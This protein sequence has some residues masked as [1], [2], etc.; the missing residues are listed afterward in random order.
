MSPVIVST[1]TRVLSAEVNP[2]S[3]T[4]V[5]VVVVVGGSVVDVVVGVEVVDG[6]DGDVARD[7]EVLCSTTVGVAALG[8]AHAATSTVINARKRRIWP[9]LS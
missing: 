7:V 2:S 9:P 1:S 6:E 8:P 5:A 3:G 4:S